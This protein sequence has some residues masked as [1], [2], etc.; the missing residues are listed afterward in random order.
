MAVFSRRF[1]VTKLPLQ[2][3]VRH[4]FKGLV[5]SKD[6]AHDTL[7]KY[8]GLSRSGVTRLLNDEG[9]G[10]ALHHIEKLC[11]FFQITPAEAV[12]EPHAVIQAVS[13][14][15]ASIL[16]IVRKMNELSRHSLLTILEWPQRSGAAATR[17][18]R[19][20][21]HLSAEDAMV[22]SLYRAMSPD[23][24]AQSGVVM[25]MRGYVQAKTDDRTARKR[26]AK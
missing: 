1:P 2:E 3:R 19:T 7:A 4:R 22:L 6:V 18:G 26:G 10:F 9:S 11:E 20:P 15:E 13:P 12:A 17:H 5:E 14:I 24:D 21:D 25:Q 8:L 16:D 23:T